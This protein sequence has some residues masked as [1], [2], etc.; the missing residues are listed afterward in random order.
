MNTETIILILVGI[1]S[2]MI[3]TGIGWIIA[4]K[5]KW[6]DNFSKNSKERTKILGDPELL[7]EKIEDSMRRLNPNAKGDAKII[8]QGEEISL[9]I[10]VE[11]GKKILKV[12]RKQYIPPKEEESPEKKAKNKGKKYWKQNKNKS[13]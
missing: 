8:D 2:I 10:E 3:G 1:L 12:N 5:T 9:D 7:K 6:L 11:K 4:K 13:K